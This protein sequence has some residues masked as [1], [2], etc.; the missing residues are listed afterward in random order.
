MD[1]ASFHRSKKVS[2][3]LEEAGISPI[4]N[5]P[6]RPQY[7]PIERVWSIVKNRYKRK[8]LE[9]VGQGQPVHHHRLVKETLDQLKHT[10]VQ[11]ICKAVL[12]KYILKV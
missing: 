6:Y 7:N 10:S 5:I 11:K 12:E 4:Y 9:I 3:Y 8:T 2:A 1:N